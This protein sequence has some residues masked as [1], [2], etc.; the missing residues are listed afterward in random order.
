MR[1]V[2]EGH[3][4][5][6]THL[7]RRFAMDR[8]EQRLGGHSITRVETHGKHL[9]IGFDHGLLLHSHLRMTGAWDVRPVDG[10]WIRSPNR[11][12]M[13]LRAGGT[14]VV[15]FDGPVLELIT[16]GRRRFDQRLSL[17]GP[18]VLAPSFDEKRYLSRLRSTNQGMTVGE[19][20]LNQ[21]ILAGIG[22][23]WKAEG[24][25]EAGVDPWRR[26]GS[27]SDQEAARIVTL[28]RPRMLESGTRGP[29]SSTG[30]LVY[31]RT[32]RA[33]PRCGHAIASRS[34]G[35]DQNRTTYWC[36]GCQH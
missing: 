21:R 29:R 32:G 2:L 27:L 10:H 33:C 26:L 30:P 8:W 7:H 23:I 16:D 11:A 25:W 17:L 22:N 12:W 13:V 24:C 34:Q 36:P 15:Q 1:P 14:E 31:R 5:E 19:A 3:V 6:V 20:L 4:V 18:D 9:L 35:D 28:V